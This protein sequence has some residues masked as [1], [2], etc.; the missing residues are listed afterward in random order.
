MLTYHDCILRPQHG[1]HVICLVNEYLADLR[2]CAAI[3][4][5][6]HACRV[7]R[8]ASVADLTQRK[9]LLSPYMAAEVV[10]DRDNPLT[11]LHAIME[12]ARQGCYRLLRAAAQT[13]QGKPGDSPATLLCKQERSTR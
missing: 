4:Q 3:R 13:S 6:P 1:P 10:P 2:R 12:A 11:A 7:R 5:I 8:V 9:K